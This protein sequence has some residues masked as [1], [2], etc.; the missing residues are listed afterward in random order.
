MQILKKHN[1]TRLEKLIRNFPGLSDEINDLKNSTFFIPI[2]KAF[3]SEVDDL[4]DGEEKLSEDAIVSI[5]KYHISP[6][7]IYSY[8]FNNN[9][10]IETGI[11][12]KAR[13][14]LYSTVRITFHE[15]MKLFNLCVLF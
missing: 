3:N 10:Q 14:N 6:Q 1:F 9:Q 11:E 7:K 4:I 15:S 8:E 2:N 5:I 13:I 12:E